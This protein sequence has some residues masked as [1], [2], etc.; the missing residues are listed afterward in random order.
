MHSQSSLLS[1]SNHPVIC[2]H[3]LT[4][5]L[6]LEQK[7]NDEGDFYYDETFQLSEV[8]LLELIDLLGDQVSYLWS[9]FL[10]F[11]RSVNIRSHLLDNIFPDSTLCNT[12][13]QYPIPFHFS[14]LNYM[15]E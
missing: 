15:E 1:I 14:I 3:L 4:S 12:T 10:K 2:L 8:K 9:I 6:F 13:I 11:H 5:V 7:L